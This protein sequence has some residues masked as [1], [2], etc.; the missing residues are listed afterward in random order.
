[1]NISEITIDYSEFKDRD[2]IDVVFEKQ[3][4]LMNYYNI[5]HID[6]DIPRDQQEV[7]ATAWNI[8]EE[9]GETLE[10]ESAEHTLDEI[11]DAMHFYIEFLIMS[12]LTSTDVKNE[13]GG[14]KQ[15][16]ASKKTIINE[17]LAEFVEALALTVNTLKNRKWRKTNLMTEKLTYMNRAV[18]TI[19]PFFKLILSFGV[20]YDEVID[21]YLR[22]NH[23]NLFRVKSKY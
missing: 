6:L 4:K 14:L 12:G 17:N 21:A 9:I 18:K 23:V 16:H 3:R 2:L 1:M 15:Q 19:Q 5:M 13:I 7:R 8:I 11:A 20:T 22:K 10:A